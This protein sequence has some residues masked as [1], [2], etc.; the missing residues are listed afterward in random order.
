M[1]TNTHHFAAFFVECIKCI[2]QIFFETAGGSKARWL[3]KLEV[4][5]VIGFETP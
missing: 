2:D 5:V 1:K 4:V 3:S